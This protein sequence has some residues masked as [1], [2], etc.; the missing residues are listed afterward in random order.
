[1]HPARTIREQFAAIALLPALFI[2]GLCPG[3]MLPATHAAT[4]GMSMM[5]GCHH[6]S[7]MQ[8]PAAPPQQKP[9]CMEEHHL[10]AQIQPVQHLHVALAATASLLPIV[11]FVVPGHTVIAGDAASPPPLLSAASTN[12]P[13][14]I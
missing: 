8:T 11:I 4:H 6:S 1:M 2:I 10:A 3:F 7:G 13:L 5:P 9:C 14:R 12:T